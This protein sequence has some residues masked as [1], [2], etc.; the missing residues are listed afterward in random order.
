MH[1]YDLPVKPALITMGSPL[2]HIY[3][4]YF[5]QNYQFTTQSNEA[6]LNWINIYRRDDF[7]GTRVHGNGTEAL[8]FKVRPKGH[9]HYWSDETVWEIFKKQGVF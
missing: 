3:G 5:H 9:S 8:N 2:T 7:V 1:A 4:H 6:L